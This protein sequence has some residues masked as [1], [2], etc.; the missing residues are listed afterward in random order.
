MLARLTAQDAAAAAA[1][2]TNSS[3]GAA[4]A[5]AA[6][7]NVRRLEKELKQLKD[8][9]EDLEL[10]NLRLTSDNQRLRTSSTLLSTSI[11]RRGGGGGGDEEEDAM[12]VIAESKAV[13][14]SR[15]HQLETDKATLKA[16]LGALKDRT[17]RWEVATLLYCS[18]YLIA[19]K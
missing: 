6:A 18:I 19:F 4:A 7:D 9:F 16:E 15:V 3:S 14:M 12:D 11:K 1:A 8:S 13:L 17:T 5:A 2:G 10:E